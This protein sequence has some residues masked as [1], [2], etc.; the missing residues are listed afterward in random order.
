MLQNKRL[1]AEFLPTLTEK[2]LEVGVCGRFVG[3]GLIF[4]QYNGLLFCLFNGQLFFGQV[5]KRAGNLSGLVTLIFD[6]LIL[7]STVFLLQSNANK[8]YVLPS[9]FPLRT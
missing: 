3:R 8:D 7:P 2:E 6:G 4:V 1:P 9:A 5:W